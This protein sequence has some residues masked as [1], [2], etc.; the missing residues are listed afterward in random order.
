MAGRTGIIVQARMGS[1]RL[2]GKV[3]ME[4]A[5]KPML[6]IL[7]GRLK[8][9][10]TADVIIVATTRNGRD[11]V[12]VKC[13]RDEDVSVY[14]GDEDDV[15]ARY[16][17]AAKE[18][19]LDTVVRVTS[20]CPLSDPYMIDDM[21]RS[22]LSADDV[23]YMSNT[24]TR[25]YPRGFDAEVFSMDSLKEAY[26]K[27]GEK[28]E[29]EHVTPYIYENLPVKAY[30]GDDD[31]SSFRVTVDTADDLRHVS[32]IFKALGHLKFIRSRDVVA[33]L[34]NRP[35]LVAINRHVEQKAVA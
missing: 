19:R 22:F 8:A 26:D 11:D 35:D 16:Y 30:A 1:S 4:I 3:M 18:Y 2:P 28:R 5:D 21:V 12:I 27:A 13:A 25:T 32:E 14:R 17:E 23:A 31:A 10:E 24:I 6:A 20:D 15:L 34:R 33:L 29:R 7:L 9:C